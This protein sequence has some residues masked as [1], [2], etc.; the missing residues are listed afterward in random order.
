MSS[1]LI[2]STNI[3]ALT[4]AELAIY[5]NRDVIAVDQDPLGQQGVPISSAHG[6]WVLTKT[7]TGGGRAV[8]LFNATNTAT[9]IATTATA[10]GLRGRHVYR[11]DNLWTGAV[12]QTGGPISAFVPGHGVAMFKVTA[13]PKRRARALPPH[14]VLSLTAASNQLEAGRSTTVY[15]SFDNNGVS[16][17]NRVALS[18]SAWPG[19]Q[20]KPLGR[21]RVPSLAAGQHFTVAYRVTAPA[22]GP[23]LVTSLLTGAVSYD[24]PSGRSTA[25]ARLGETVRGPIRT[26]LLTADVTT[27]P[28]SFGSSGRALAISSRGVGVFNPPFGAAPTDSY[29]AIYEHAKA[30]RSSV[31]QV[32]VLSD[33]AGGVSGGAGLIERDDMTARDGSPA[34]VAL[35]ISSTATI[36]MSWNGSGR[37][38]V[39]Q[40]FTVPSVI[41]KAP[42][43]LRLVRNGSAYTGYYSTDGGKAWR[44]VATATVAA[45]ASNGTQDVGVF[46]ASG[47]PTWTT[48]ARFRDF[49]VR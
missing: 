41:V 1:P 40:H 15:E 49:R 7:L 47:L 19:W 29:A 12:S 45:T 11:L 10:T 6:L 23:P 26:P 42:V 30:R 43:A 5:E 44:L 17:V 22:S 21:A 9:T 14:T 13:V 33:P 48:T 34:A 4:P 36:V 46:H 38:D 24:P 16:K 39:D 28:A 37:A 20:I 35:F 3:A 31:A 25:T 32:T 2:A 8:V 18:L 27:H